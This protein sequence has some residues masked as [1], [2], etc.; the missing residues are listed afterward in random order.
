[1]TRVIA[2]R[3][4]RGYSDQNESTFRREVELASLRTDTRLNTLD[5]RTQNLFPVSAFGAVGDGVTDDSD[6]LEAAVTAAA[7]VNGTL[8][9]T[10]GATY[11]LFRT[12]Y[13][14][15]RI[16][17]EFNNTTFLADSTGTYDPVLGTGGAD[18]GLDV[19][20]AMD[21]AESS[22]YH[23]RLFLDGN[24]VADLCGIS[25]NDQGLS[26]FQTWER[27]RI[28]NFER[29]IYAVNNQNQNTLVGH[30]FGLV[31][32][33]SNGYDIYVEGNGADD[34]QFGEVRSS[35]SAFLADAGKANIYLDTT[36]AA[37]LIH[38]LFLNGQRTDRDGLVL[39]DGASFIC[40]RMFIEHDFLVPVR[41]RNSQNTLRVE[42]LDVSTTF[43][44]A[45]DSVIEFES[46]DLRGYYDVAFT[47]RV[48]G[49]TGVTTLVRISSVA[50]S[51]NRVIRIRLPF[52][53]GSKTPVT[54]VGGGTGHDELVEVI[55]ANGVFRFFYDGT[56][57]T[58]VRQDT[59]AGTHTG[60]L[61]G[62]L[63]SVTDRIEVFDT[64]GNSLGFVPI[65]DSI[66]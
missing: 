34:S 19:F 9:F 16:R 48:T 22:I 12:L 36:P 59:F 51:K 61:T 66:T 31:E 2:G 33:F 5:T 28:S 40:D 29:G 50:G 15:Q 8:V 42:A 23:G 11:R 1:M 24:Q 17:W 4:D 3:P 49:T 14:A 26:G 13:G 7:E 32:F 60:S 43:S 57:T 46:N 62:T 53:T 41:I 52:G 58:A 65:Y 27:V 30:R 35:G 47:D 37:L 56:T 45:N 39:D 55:A 38:A 64:A 44:S 25:G 6:A 20:F 63:G 18:T 21:G 54:Y 10:P